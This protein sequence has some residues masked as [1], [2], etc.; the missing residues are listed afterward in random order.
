MKVSN[1]IKT[2]CMAVLLC[3]ILAGCGG[4]KEP[5]K[6]DLTVDTAALAEKLN[7]E[8]VTSDTLTEANSS[9]IPTIYMIDAGDIA[10]ASA[11]TSSGATACEV[12]VIELNDA[13]KS[14]DVKKLFEARVKNQ[15]ELY[16]SYNAGEVDKL[17]KAV[18]DTEGKYAVLVVCD[19]AAKAQEILKE[20]G[21]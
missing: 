16:A 15:S 18:I 6:A 3:G 9:I 8:T 2:A 19:D 7:T 5:A 4:K 21:F 17:D 13:A 14:E 1:A 12:A 20:A 11:Y 10:N